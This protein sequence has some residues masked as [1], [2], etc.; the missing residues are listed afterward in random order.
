[1]AEFDA[2]SVHKNDWGVMGG[3]ALVLIASF[4]TWFSVD[5]SGLLNLDRNGWNNGFLG[6]F[7]VL[8]AIAAAGIVAARVFG[9]DLPKAPVGWRTIVLG[10]S[11]LAALCIV[12][13]LLIGFHGWSR[14]IGLFLAVIGVVLEAAF[15]YLAFAASGER[16][17]IDR[18][19]A[20]R[21]AKAAAATPAPAAAGGMT[22]P[23]PP[24]YAAPVAPVVVEPPLDDQSHDHEGHDHDGH[25]HDGHDHDGHD[26]DG[27]HE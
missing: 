16:A 8:C 12:L 26:H 24:G 3:G 22:P 27:L 5:L 11:G 17:D 19:R 9:V 23:P 10:L 4:L 25:G 13:K 2:K 6:W 21:A 15:A 7:G 1:M 20:E 18:M 14:G